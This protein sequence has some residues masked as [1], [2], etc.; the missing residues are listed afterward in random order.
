MASALSE[1]EF[2]RMQLQ[3]LELRT[4]NYELEGK[5]RKLEREL[6]E[7]S[8][9]IE[10]LDK[11]LAKANKAISKS[12]KAKETELLLQ[13]NDSL[14]RKLLS[15][16]EEFRLQNQTLMTELSMLVAINEKLENEV[17]D[18][19]AFKSTAKVMAASDDKSQE[20]DDQV[21][22]LQ[23]QK[24]ALQKNLAALQEKY[25]KE[26]S[27]LQHLLHMTAE[28]ETDKG[29]QSPAGSEDLK[30]EKREVEGQ[31]AED[32][33]QAQVV[34]SQLAQ[35]HKKVESLVAEV[36]E[37]QLNLDTEQ[38]EKRLLKEQLHS[39]EKRLKEQIASLQEEVEKLN[40]KLRR[41][42]DSLLQLQKE[43]ETLFDENKRKIDEL[44]A[45]RERDQ[46]YYHEQIVKLQQDLVKAHQSQESLK[47]ESAERVQELQHR[48]NELQKH[49]DA[50]NIVG[51]H[52]IQELNNKHKQEMKELH[53]Q[54]KSLAQIN[55]DLKVQLQESLRASEETIG[56]LHAAQQERD[57][58]IQALQEINKVAEKRK[59]LLDELAIKY[60]KEHDMH[61]EQSIAAE[62]KHQAQTVALETEIDQMKVRLQE[63]SKQ[64][65][66]IEELQSKIH[67]L[68]DAKGWLERSLK[69]TEEH[70][71]Q[72]QQGMEEKI[73]ALKAEHQAHVESMLETH[74]TE[75]KQLLEGGERKVQEWAAREE[76]LQ[77]EIDNL[78]YTVASLR[79]NIK[80]SVDEKK[81]H[82][83]K[84]MAMLK[85]LKRQLHAERKRA[86]KLQERLQE[87]LSEN[88][89]K[90]MEELF[91]PADSG[92]LL[93]CDG[94]SVSSWSTGA[95]G[96][97]KD[98]TASG[99]QSPSG[100]NHSLASVIS[101]P[102]EEY[103]EIL[104][105]IA[106]IQEEKW[107][108]EEKV[109][110]LETSNACMADDLLEKSAII[111]HYV[112][113]SNIVG[114]RRQS[115]HVEEPKLSLRKVMEL[116]KSG[117]HSELQ[118][119][120]RKLQ[121]MLEETLTKNMHL[122]QDLEVMSQEVVRLS[123]LSAGGMLGTE[124][125]GGKQDAP[126][127]PANPRGGSTGPRTPRAVGRGEQKEA[128]VDT[129]L[130]EGEAASDSSATAVDTSAAHIG[131]EAAADTEDTAADNADDA[132]PESGGDTAV[133][134]SESGRNE[135]PTDLLIQNNDR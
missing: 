97:G 63:S 121:R 123:R 8:E 15:Q 50:A 53:N 93:H 106:H 101:D 114:G 1:E 32:A 76:K 80:D 70:L 66:L 134:R 38:E 30:E 52:Q 74:N 71:Q 98:S 17:A 119:M 103:T 108:L 5:C 94:S 92:D 112:M 96:L 43:K 2:H 79:Q 83:K 62:E 132:G 36:K 9:K 23:A 44:T 100:I 117:D 85:D 109:R 99:P 116:V 42:Q 73:Q 29:R 21:R 28:L 91:T 133:A 41:K 25:E 40:E 81:I 61:R 135:P 84:G 111:Q 54:L 64:V 10:T 131:Q 107:S 82:E 129:Q 47:T 65:L 6:T 130:E 68:E 124:G 95:S 49:V 77:E 34:S 90:S 122:Q 89:S 3:L 58:Q 20:T 69:E 35:S 27:D 113:N 88:K 67:A 26:V 14:Q 87:V 126:V 39:S 72:A 18:L 45:G 4:T 75:V 22:H 12:K 59:A 46:K 31:T 37:L 60:Q 56:Q 24:A 104:Q 86:E 102:G 16:E 13:E 7:S 33:A 48:V 51:S 125:S 105:R 120:N 110:H 127:S 128:A 19:R 78:N 115:Q 118:D 55:D 57:S 11:E